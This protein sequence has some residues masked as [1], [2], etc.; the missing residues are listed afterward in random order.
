[1]IAWFAQTFETVFPVLLKLGVTTEKEVGLATLED[2]LRESVVAS[3]HS[4]LVG[5]PQY[6]AWVRV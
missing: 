2:R 5:P 4:Q 1:M 3:P 6:C